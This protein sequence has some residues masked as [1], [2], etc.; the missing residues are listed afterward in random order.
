MVWKVTS[1]SWWSLYV[2]IL[3][4]ARP[5]KEER[6]IHLSYGSYGAPL[7]SVVSAF[8]ALHCTKHHNV[9]LSQAR[10]ALGWVTNC[11]QQYRLIKCNP[12]GIRSS[13]LEV[14]FKLPAIWPQRSCCPL[15]ATSDKY[16]QGRFI[17]LYRNQHKGAAIEKLTCTS[18]YISSITFLA[19]CAASAPHCNPLARNLRHSYIWAKNLSMASHT[20]WSSL[21]EIA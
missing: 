11:R 8:E 20:S 4:F 10:R 21:E 18:R 6:K 2:I 1:T 7:Y 14:H 16:E 17:E 3:P 12:H 15:S 9:G 5:P 19:Y 13:V